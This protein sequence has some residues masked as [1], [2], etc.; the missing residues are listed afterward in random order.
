MITKPQEGLLNMIYS[1]AWQ[2]ALTSVQCALVW[3][4]EGN[5]FTDTLNPD[6]RDALGMG[7]V[8]YQVIR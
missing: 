2:G 8:E 5:K 4:N 6:L 3:S 1:S 7:D